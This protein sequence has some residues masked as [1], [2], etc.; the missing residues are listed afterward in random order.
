[1]GIR[2]ATVTR[3]PLAKTV[4]AVGFLRAPEMGLV[5]V[6]L[7]ISGWIDKLYANQE[8]MH[9][10]KGEP[11]FDLYSPDLQVAEEELISATKTLH[12]LSPDAGDQVRKESAM[13][14]AS[15]RRKL[16]LWG[17]ADQDIDAIAKASEMPRTVTFRS[18]ANGTIVD[19][20]VV[21]GSAVPA[22]AKLMRIED[23]SKLW[24]DIQVYEEQMPFIALG[25]NVEAVVDGIPGRTF[26]AAIHF[27]HPHV[28]PMT[29]TVT[30]RTT[31]DN[32]AMKMKP[33]M[34]ATVNILT[35]PVADTIQIPREAV[36]DTGTRQIAFVVQSEGHFAPR[37]VRM[38]VE[39][40]NDQVQILEG[41]VPGEVVVTSGQFLL[42]VES[43]TTEAIQKLQDKPSVDATD[44][45]APATTDPS[46]IHQPITDQSTTQP[47]TTPTDPSHSMMIET[48]P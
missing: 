44:V 22:G 14:V 15:A 18:P 5:D 43:R 40:D 28:D 4:R 46:R 12:A 21:E 37:K 23:H 6:S 47:A 8:G 48:H 42:D 1:M 25:Q 31:L 26:T 34:Y 13:F 24:L 41:L 45:P 20:S 29:R 17:V 11:L 7:K 3:G 9:V 36:I 35:H 2:T 32:T 33:G 10:N 27:I 30:V 16:Q 38:G 19:T 39:G